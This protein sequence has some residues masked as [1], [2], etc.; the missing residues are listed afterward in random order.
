L[1]RLCGILEEKE[2]TITRFEADLVAGSIT[3]NTELEN[4]VKEQKEAIL[5]NKETVRIIDRQLGDARAE[6]ECMQ[7]LL[8]E[9][10]DFIRVQSETAGVLEKELAT[11]RADKE[12][13]HTGRLHD[14]ETWATQLAARTVALALNEATIKELQGKLIQYKCTEEE[15]TK[16]NLDVANDLM[17][18][19]DEMR[20]ERDKSSALSLE[21]E[22][23]QTDLLSTQGEVQVL[24]ESLS[25]AREQA[26]NVQSQLALAGDEKQLLQKRISALEVECTELRKEIGHGSSFSKAAVEVGPG[27]AVSC[28]TLS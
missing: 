6:N 21:N 5:R 16:K 24:S 17:G 7:A 20:Q 8:D 12:A 27:F 1:Q 22:R 18:L 23:L 10:E 13:S 15:L 26:N 25:A 28:K 3:A 2:K 11:A 4:L 14:A 19:Q 9:K